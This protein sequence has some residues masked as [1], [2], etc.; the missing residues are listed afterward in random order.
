MR[1]GPLDWVLISFDDGQDERPA[2][3]GFEGTREASE[4]RLCG[5]KMLPHVHRPRRKEK[6]RNRCQP[7]GTPSHMRCCK[8]HDEQHRQN[9]DIEVRALAPHPRN[10]PEQN[11]KERGNAQPAAIPLKLGIAPPGCP[12]P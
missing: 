1:E 3:N 4:F 5:G 12:K 6:K 7:F 8:N 9:A 11:K 10:R 2:W